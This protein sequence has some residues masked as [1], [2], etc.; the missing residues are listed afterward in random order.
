MALRENEL[1]DHHR[2]NLDIGRFKNPNKNPVAEKAFAEPD[3]K[4]LRQVPGGGPVSQLDFLL[5]Q[6]GLT[7]VSV[8][9]ACQHEKCI[10]VHTLTT[11][12]DRP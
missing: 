1:L 2:I 10:S 12:H 11:S 5:P 7:P 9:A 4:I 3:E 6:Q 8:M